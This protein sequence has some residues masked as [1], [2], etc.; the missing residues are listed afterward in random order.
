M[1][2]HDVVDPNNDKKEE[3]IYQDVLNMWFADL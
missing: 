2:I 1:S 3:L